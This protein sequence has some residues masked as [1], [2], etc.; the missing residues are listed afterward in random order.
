MTSS[1]A[2]PYGSLRGVQQPRIASVPA[3]S[4]SAGDDVIAVA[5]LAG[6]ELDP[7]QQM[8]LA[9]GL[10]ESSD[11]KCPHCTYRVANPEPCP[12]HPRVGLIHP[13]SA[14]EVAEVVPRQNGKSEMLIA[15]I[16]GG[17]FVLEEPLQ[18]YSAHLFDTA[19]EIMRRLAYVVE[20]C[21]DLRREVKH[22][23]RRMVGIKYGH[24]DEGIEL[25]SG[26]RVRFKART[27]GGGRGFSCDCL[28]LDEAMI[29]PEAFLGATIPTLSARANPQLWLAGSPP[30]EDDPSHDGVVLARRRERAIA[31][32]DPSLAYFEHSA[33]GVHPALV[34]EEILN[35]P[36]Q[37]ALANPG[38]GIRITPEYIANERRAMGARQFAVERLGIGAWPS[39]TSDAGRVIARDVWASCAERDEAERISTRTTFAIDTNLDQTWASIAVAGL[40]A[41][42][43]PQ[44]AIVFHQIGADWVVDRCAEIIKDHPGAA[45]VV[46]KLGPAKN[47]VD[48]LVGVGIT[49]AEA[50]SQDYG[51]ACADFVK[52][53]T[54]RRLRYPAPQP[55]LDEALAGARQQPLGDRW[56]WSRKGSTA[57][58][59]SPL[60][61]CTLA[62]WGVTQHEPQKP[63][64]TWRMF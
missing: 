63:R 16:L 30:D 55:D 29:L 47:L 54:E 10:G 28:Y 14:F 12:S 34:G 57:P 35:D 4:S 56:K 40:R 43:L 60:V 1:L 48:G 64:D 15:R 9:G 26:P 45:F 21:D 51:T 61:A 37:W 50:T 49:P 17:L 3:Y 41:D 6:I 32:N 52:A 36:E 62:L 11:W 7:W 22:R 13:W 25:A 18:I 42:G 20:N 2:A 8:E 33:D 23:G 27:G 39:T 58:D 46:E 19:T 38:L 53:A 44:I 24:G 5:R 59:I 31:G